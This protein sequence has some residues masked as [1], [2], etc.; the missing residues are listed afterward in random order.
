MGLQKEAVFAKLPQLFMHIAF[1][2]TSIVLVGCVVYFV[3][4]EL[5]LGAYGMSM[6]SSIVC[7]TL[8]KFLCDIARHITDAYEIY[9]SFYGENILLLEGSHAFDGVAKLL[10]KI[11][12]GQCINGVAIA[13]FGS[14]ISY[15][16]FAGAFKVVFVV[17]ADGS[18]SKGILVQEAVSWWCSSSEHITLEFT[19]EGDWVKAADGK[20]VKKPSSMMISSTSRT[21]NLRFLGYCSSVYY[22]SEE[23]LPRVRPRTLLNEM[24]AR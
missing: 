4:S 11:N 9:K 19:K 20:F 5:K 8:P 12:A 2:V 3:Q 23:E 1:A 7:W 15:D 24:E 21:L 16:V 22:T 18:M 13:R 14:F 10:E 6:C 17:P